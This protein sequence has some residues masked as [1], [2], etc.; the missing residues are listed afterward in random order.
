MTTTSKQKPT[1]L[2]FYYHSIISDI[3]LEILDTLPLI[4]YPAFYFVRCA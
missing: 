1:Q 2:I 3:Y 4:L